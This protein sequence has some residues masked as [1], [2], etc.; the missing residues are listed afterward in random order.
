[1]IK[2]FE[3][4]DNHIGKKYDRY[5]SI[6]E[7][8]INSRFESLQK[9]VHQAES[10][11]CDFFVLTG[12]LFDNTSGIKQQDV[13]KVVEI[14]AEF[15][16][17][18][19]LLPGNHDYYTSEEK[20]WK[21]FSNELKKISHNITLLTE[22]R[23]YIFEVGDEVVVVYPAPC[24][25][26]HSK[27]NAL[28]WIK[29]TNIPHDEIYRVGIAHGSIQGLTPDMNQV[30]FLMTEAELN[31]IPMDVWLIGHTHVPYP[32][33][34]ETPVFGNKIYNAGTHEQT[35]LSN[36]T[37]GYGFIIALENDNSKKVIS[38]HSYKSGNIRYYDKKDKIE[39]NKNISLKDLI[40]SLIKGVERNSVI[41]IEIQGSLTSEEYI[42][43]DK[44]YDELLSS[45]LH[46]EII[47]NDL[48]EM[49]SDK[50]I[51]AEFS[52]LSFAAQLLQ[53]LDDPKERQMAYNLINE[54]REKLPE[55]NS[56]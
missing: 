31:K 47:D 5:T 15:N 40:K 49:I 50:K 37:E 51:K 6:K 10:Q 18:V 54:F 25:S 14:L 23:E 24:Q 56:K 30:Y 22:M 52:E 1:M 48:S 53:A 35:D 21:D 26:K 19:L 32:K 17:R 45:F 12:D 29:N 33:L 8:L 9:M 16:G 44:I 43:K 2:I 28:G 3:T 27:E 36:N 39:P 55:S 41:R 46:F 11:H 13:K 38:A 42:S 7:K 4:G 20:V 34:S